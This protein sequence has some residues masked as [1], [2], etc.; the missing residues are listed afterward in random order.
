M[1]DVNKKK[2][3]RELGH[4]EFILPQSKKWEWIW[5]CYTETDEQQTGDEN[6]G[7]RGDYQ[8]KE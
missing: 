5:F 7:K 6:H 4:T 8:G 1:K 2:Y 3:I